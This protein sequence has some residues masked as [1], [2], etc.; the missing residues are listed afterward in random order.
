MSEVDSINIR[1]T[2]TDEASANIQRVS[3][4]LNSLNSGGRNAQNV[5]AG[6]ESRWTRTGKSM[7]DVGGAIDD[8]T[9]PLQFAAAGTLALGVASGKAAMD[10]ETAFTGVRK[11]VDGTEEQFVALNKGLR[12]MSETTPVAAKDLANLA[13]VGGQLGVGIENIEK[14]T[15]VIADMN[16]A[17]NLTGEEGAATLAQFMNVMGE[18]IDNVDRA[19]SSIVDLGNHSATTE[20]DIAEMAQRMGSFARSVGIGTPQVLG[21]A[22]ALASMG[23][24][25]QAGGSAIGRTWASI[26]KAVSSG[27]ESLEAFAKYAGVSAEEFKKQWNTDAS[28]AFN[29]FIKGLSQSKDLTAALEEVGI[30]NTLDVTAI[31]LRAK[32]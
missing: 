13:A 1:I 32:G 25:A 15:K 3:N 7:K 31:Q 5:A 19:G 23:V 27:G 18:D 26:Q 16:V 12:N 17:T 20:R 9:K 2:A 29:G 4:S 28:G 21:Y 8:I 14:F 30:N 10:Y 24:E 22:A 11:T 6:V